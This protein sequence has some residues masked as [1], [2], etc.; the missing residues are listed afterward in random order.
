MEQNDPLNRNISRLAAGVGKNRY[1]DLFANINGLE[2]LTFVFS[3]QDD[4]IGTLDNDEKSFLISKSVNLI[5]IEAPHS[6]TVV[7][8]IRRGYAEGLQLGN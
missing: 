7:S 1:I 4:R 3:T 5:P 8:G 6:E 2:K